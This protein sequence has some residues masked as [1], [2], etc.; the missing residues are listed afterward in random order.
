MVMDSTPTTADQPQPH[1]KSDWH[2]G[3][4]D[5]QTRPAADHKPLDRQQGEL[6]D[7]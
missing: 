6:L 1:D 5:E 4:S 2:A 7:D 3:E